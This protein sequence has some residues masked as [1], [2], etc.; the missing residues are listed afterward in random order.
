MEAIDPDFPNKVNSGDII[1]GGLNF[2]CGSSR[3]HAPMVIKECGVS[4]IIAKTFARIFYRNCINIGLSILECPEA[5]D[6]IDEGNEVSINFETGEITNL[7]KS[8]VYR[9]TPFPDFINEIISANG[10]INSISQKMK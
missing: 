10:L 1:I 6:D 8:K 5:V 9:A 3:E 7:T 2:G 4:C